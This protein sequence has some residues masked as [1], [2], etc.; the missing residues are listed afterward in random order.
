MGG[1]FGSFYVGVSGLQASQNSLHTTSHNVVNA[2]TPDYTR[3]RLVQN[4]RVYTNVGMYGSGTNQVGKGTLIASVNQIRDV[5]L[6]QAYRREF[7][8]QGFYEAQYE[9]IQEVEELYGELEGVQ[10]QNTLENLWNSMQELAKEP[11][12]IVTR[13]SLIQSAGSFLERADSIYNQLKQYQQKLNTQVKNSV[14]RINEIGHEIQHLNGIIRSCESTTENAND[15]RDQRNALLDELGKLVN[16]TYHE[17]DDGMVSVN[18]EGSMF[19]T[20]INVNEIT[21]EVSENELQVY[22]PIWG[23]GERVFNLSVPFSSEANND[24]GFLKGLLLARGDEVGNYTD[25]PVEPDIRYYQDAEGEWDGDGE[26]Q[27]LAAMAKYAQDVEQYNLTTGRSVI[28]NVQAQFDQLVHGMVTKLND[29]LSPTITGIWDEASGEITWRDR[30]GNP[31]PEEDIPLLDAGDFADFIG[32]PDADPDDPD[33]KSY[34]TPLLDANG[35]PTGRYMIK[36]L[37]TKHAPAGIDSEQTVGEGL[38]NRKSENRFLQTEDTYTIFEG[39]EEEP[40]YI[41]V[42]ENQNDPYSIFSLGEIELNPAVRDNVSKLPLSRSAGTGDYDMNIAEELI[43]AWDERF[44][45]LNPNTLTKNNFMEY[46]TAF[47]SD[48]ANTGQVLKSIM[49]NQE[50]TTEGVDDQRQQIMGVSSDE[51]LTYLIKFQHSYN[52]ASRYIT[53][54]DE[55]LEHILTHL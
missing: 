1:L 4:D 24:I 11:D 38:F 14:E 6:D 25:I 46:Y 54:I 34:V 7:G 48:I 8:R 42:P 37:D 32:D 27:Y 3:Q 45:T 13:A 22:H 20:E 43:A 29:I 23:D 16:Y 30:L 55:M 18:I 19:V 21:L 44:A 40:L 28:M 49:D 51:E 47:T 9:A 26:E 33:A 50:L 31:L 12:S 36:I 52:A 53:V 2:D 41:Y 35:Q 5:F 39:R 15:Y 17:Y 10:F